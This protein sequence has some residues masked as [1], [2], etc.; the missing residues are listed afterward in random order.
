[1]LAQ[2]VEKTFRDLHRRF[3]YLEERGGSFE[4]ELQEK[5]DGTKG[6]AIVIEPNDSQ[7]NA[8]GVG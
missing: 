5:Q 1:M 6:A 8:K 4:E 7:T 3:A 2:N